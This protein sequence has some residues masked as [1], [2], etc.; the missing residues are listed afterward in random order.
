MSL[1]KLAKTVFSTG[2][3]DVLIVVDTYKK[4]DSKVVNS[5]QEIADNLNDANGPLALIK[6]ASQGLPDISKI[7]DDLKSLSPGDLL[8]KITGGDGSLSSK[9][10]DLSSG[11]QNAFKVATNAASVVKAVFNGETA[12]LLKRGYS[13]AKAIA[14]MVNDFTKGKY[15]VNFKDLG[16]ISGLITGLA[17]KGSRLGLPNTFST[18]AKEITDKAVLLTSAGSLIQ[19]AIKNKDMNLFLDMVDSP[20]AKDMRNLNPNAILGMVKDFKFDGPRPGSGLSGYYDTVVAGF[21]KVDS[22]WK[23]VE[24][25][26]STAISAAQFA[27]S[28]DFKKMIEAKALSIP[29]IIPKPFN[30]VV[31][32]LLARADDEGFLTM[33]SKFKF[34]TVKEELSKLLPSIKINTAEKTADHDCNASNSLQFSADATGQVMIA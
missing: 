32:P 4:S 30:G 10:R 11:V 16:S 19:T 8:K 9:F 2:P 22:T 1:S 5:I 17:E 15:S 33:A 23:Q 31:P 14:G 34:S 29:L 18:M 28:G 12:Q 20:I 26:G 25:L 13:D 24:R 6:K 27:S 3:D 21:N 7:A